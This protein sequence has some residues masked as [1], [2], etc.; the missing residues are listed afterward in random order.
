MRSIDDSGPF[1]GMNTPL[2]PGAA[3]YIALGGG[4]VTEGTTGASRIPG[5]SGFAKGLAIAL[6][7]FAN[8]IPT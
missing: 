5:Y 6:A 7:G 3:R 8:V 4:F 1:G 2:H